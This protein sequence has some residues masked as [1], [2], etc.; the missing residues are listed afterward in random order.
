MQIVLP[1]V[2]QLLQA[3]KALVLV[4]M[5]RVAEAHFVSENC[6]DPV[7]HDAF[8]SHVDLWDLLLESFL[9]KT[10]QAY[11]PAFVTSFFSLEAQMAVAG[12]CLGQAW[13]SLG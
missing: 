10:H 9:L 5:L 11:T 8:H 7:A 3:T 2:Y 4:A 1:L 13:H 6:L 12:L